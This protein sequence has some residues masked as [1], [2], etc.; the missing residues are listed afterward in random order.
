VKIMGAAMNDWRKQRD[1]LIEE[2]LAFTQRLRSDVPKQFEFPN[3]I[4]QALSSVAAIQPE[5]LQ[6]P[7]AAEVPTPKNKLDTERDVVRRRLANFK[8]TQRKFQQGR[9]E[10]YTRTMSAALATQ[11]TSEGRDNGR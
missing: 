3:T 10:Y 6:L 4:P 9:E 2:T 11:W 1:L 7:R 5:P 8:A